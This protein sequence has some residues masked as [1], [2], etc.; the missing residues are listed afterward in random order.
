MILTNCFNPDKSEVQNEKFADK[1][2]EFATE[3]SIGLK[4]LLVNNTNFPSLIAILLISKFTKLSVKFKSTISE[5]FT[6]SSLFVNV[7]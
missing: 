1:S 4:F 7:D 5:S 6:K 3:P 2:I